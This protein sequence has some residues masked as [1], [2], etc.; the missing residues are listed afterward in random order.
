[1]NLAG[2]TLFVTGASRGIGLAIGLR[3]ARDGANVVVVAKT[4]EPHPKLPGTIF[5]AAAEIEAAGGHALAVRCNVRSEDGEITHAVAAAVERSGGIDVVVNNASAAIRLARRHGADRREGVRPDDVDRPPRHL[6]RHAGGA[7]ASRAGAANPHILTLAPPIALAVEVG[8]RF[9]GVHVQEIRDDAA[10]ARGS[11]PE[12]ASAGSPPTHCG[13]ARRSRPP[14]C[15]TCW[16]ATRSIKASRTPDIVADA[17]YLDPRFATRA[18]PPATR[19]S[20]RACCARTASRTC[21]A[22]PCRPARR[23][24]RTSSSTRREPDRRAHR[25]RRG[26]R[27]PPRRGWSR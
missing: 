27:S 8:R 4:V 2:K 21:P 23:S 9:A 25:A 17:A 12:F 14:R 7:P 20:T 5:T 26:R 15:R 11:P 3:A 18:P 10:D 22:T 1:M 13:R 24:C 16:A 6:S 19:S